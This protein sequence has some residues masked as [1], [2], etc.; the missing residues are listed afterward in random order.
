MCM[1]L[2]TNAEKATRNRSDRKGSEYAVNCDRNVF[3]IKLIDCCLMCMLLAINSIEKSVPSGEARLFRKCFQIQSRMPEQS[4]IQSTV[5]CHQE[6]NETWK[7]LVTSDLDG[8]SNCQ[9]PFNSNSKQADNLYWC[10]FQSS[11]AVH[12]YFDSHRSNNVS[13]VQD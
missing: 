11:T 3:F 4:I 13:V 7:I 8:V 1:Y 5:L 2:L 10:L 9:T 12:A 6:I